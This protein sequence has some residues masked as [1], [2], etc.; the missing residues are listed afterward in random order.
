MLIPDA[1]TAA[2]V[3]AD[4]TEENARLR[5]HVEELENATPSSQAELGVLS[6][7]EMDEI[8]LNRQDAET[9]EGHGLDVAWFEDDESWWATIVIIHRNGDLQTVTCDGDTRAKALR[10]LVER[11]K[12]AKA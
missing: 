9:D 1:Q 3:I 2:E 8:W 12:E 11:V 10:T 4:L 5:A 7:E 6:Q